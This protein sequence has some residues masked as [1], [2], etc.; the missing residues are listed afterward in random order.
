M[1]SL[2]RPIPTSPWLN[3][4]DVH[5]MKAHVQGGITADMEGIVLIPD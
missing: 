2:G 1:P 4:D 5:C 3:D